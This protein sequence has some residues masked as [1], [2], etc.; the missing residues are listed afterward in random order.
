MTLLRRFRTLKTTEPSEPRDSI[1]EIGLTL[2][3]KPREDTKVEAPLPAS[4]KLILSSVVFVHGFLGHPKK[5]WAAPGD[6]TTPPTYWPREKVPQSLPQARVW[7]FGYDTKLSHP[8]RSGSQNTVYGEGKELVAILD[9]VRRGNEKLLPIIFV[10]HSLGGIVVKQALRYSEKCK[11]HQANQSLGLANPNTIATLLP[12][13]AELEQLR[14]EF[15]PMARKKQ[16]SITSF[17]E[18]RGVPFLNGRLV[19]DQVS[20][21]LG[22]R[23]VERTRAIDKNHMEMCK[24]SAEDPEY[25]KVDQTLRYT[26]ETFTSKSAQV[27]TVAPP[28]RITPFVQTNQLERITEEQKKR[29]L[30]TLRWPEM[31]SRENS[32]ESPSLDTVQWIFGENLKESDVRK[33]FRQWLQSADALFWIRGKAG[34]GKSTLMKFLVH[35]KR[36][37]K[38]LVVWNPSVRI[39]HFFFIEVG[40]SPLQRQIEGCLRSLLYQLLI[41]DGVMLEN[42]LRS[43]PSLRQKASEHDW[44]IEDLQRT[45]IN[46]LRMS[47]TTFCLFIDEI[48]NDSQFSAAEALLAL[49]HTQG[50]KVCV[51]SRE[52]NSLSALSLYP[53]LRIQD[54]TYG[55]INA[56][57]REKLHPSLTELHELQNGVAS[58]K[59]R[60]MV[61]TLTVKSD[62]VFLWAV[63]AVENILQGIRDGDSFQILRKGTDEFAPSLD[64]L[65]QQMWSRR[66]DNNPKQQRESAEL[67]WLMLN[68]RELQWWPRWF[69]GNLFST[70]I[71]LR[72][73]FEDFIQSKRTPTKQYVQAL[74]QEHQ[75][76]LLARSAGLIEITSRSLTQASND[77]TFFTPGNY[78]VRFIH[79][80]VREFLL[81][82]PSGRA[83]L[84]RDTRTSQEKW[85]NMLRGLKTTVMF[86]GVCR[87][88]PCQGFLEG[89]TS[90]PRH[91]RSGAFDF[92]TKVLPSHVIRGHISDDDELRLLN[93]LEYATHAMSGSLELQ[94]ILLVCAATYGS[95]KYVSQKNGQRLENLADADKTQLLFAACAN[96]RN[97]ITN[98]IP[99]EESWG[100]ATL[101]CSEELIHLKPFLRAVHCIRYV[102][103]AG[104]DAN[105]TF[106]TDGPEK[107]TTPFCCMLREI[108]HASLEIEFT[109]KDGT[110]MESPRVVELGRFYSEVGSFI[111]FWT[112]HQADLSGRVILRTGGCDKIWKRL[113]IVSWTFDFQIPVVWIVEYMR[114][115]RAFWTAPWQKSTSSGADNRPCSIKCIAMGRFRMTKKKFNT[116][117]N[118]VGLRLGA[119]FEELL[120][121][122]WQNQNGWL[123]R[124]LILNYI[125]GKAIRLRERSYPL[126][127]RLGIRL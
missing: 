38:H 7:A 114:R 117:E 98:I 64:A 39:L 53:S 70:N 59:V 30:S 34:S 43:Q 27:N 14:D 122:P 15:L 72:Q 101:D 126:P 83:I 42:I 26:W 119:A 23:D 49:A 84:D 60:D 85:S 121:R 13:S 47:K 52:E 29:F 69:I 25:G 8:L 94:W 90:L 67:F 19:A 1:G 91:P 18:Q 4:P 109:H 24:F 20:S 57:I 110:Y 37:M 81:S 12:N 105:A 125:E 80:S 73:A 33:S 31:N 102:L 5:T 88:L 118:D 21:C 82:T 55:G 106:S 127:P 116:T 61:N 11:E 48:K 96:W 79:R 50:V 124:V 77:S 113:A 92:F 51:S 58:Q 78:T 6:R 95:W 44:S 108:L 68:S 22:D 111:D 45:L 63:M 104:A 40:T 41:A 86:T 62:G 100:K 54:L 28:G 120:L 76:W 2:I 36:T 93:E 46:A 75:K 66:N 9:D 97:V 35:E 103:S 99:D 17:Q 87:I 16:W 115:R 65:Y 123:F 112:E 3:A 89:S 32:I 56:Y 107:N 74:M 10:A 71:H